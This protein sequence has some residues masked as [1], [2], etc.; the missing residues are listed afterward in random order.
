MPPIRLALVTT[1]P[2]VV[3]EKS[4]MPLDEVECT[5]RV[6]IGLVVPMPTLALF[7]LLMGALVPLVHCADAVREPIT[8]ISS[9]KLIEPI[10]I[11]VFDFCEFVF[12]FV[13]LSN[14]PIGD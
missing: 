8:N 9:A 5:S 11:F 6:P 4:G 10:Q 1:N 7:V 13:P 12:I 14:V 2:S 3:L